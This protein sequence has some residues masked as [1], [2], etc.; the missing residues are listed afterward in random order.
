MDKFTPQQREAITKEGSNLLV[1]ASAGAGKTTVLVNRLIRKIKDGTNVDELLV[2]TFTKA[3]A[4]EMKTRISQEIHA[5]LN[6]TDDQEVKRHLTKQI[7]LI[8][9]ANI[10]T[11]HSFC[12]KVIQRY[13]YMI[14]IDPVFRMLTDDT[15]KLLLKEE[16]L[17]QIFDQRLAGGD[18][19]FIELLN[20][21]SSDRNLDQAKEL[22][23]TVYEFAVSKPDPLNWL[24]NLD[25]LYQN[26]SANNLGETTVYT[27]YLK[28]QFI[29]FFQGIIEEYDYILDRVNDYPLFEKSA[30]LLQKEKD[31]CQALIESIKNGELVQV[32]DCLTSQP[33]GRY[34]T[35]P[36]DANEEEKAFNTANRELRNQLKDQL[37]DF[38]ERYFHTD[39]KRLMEI[40]N[41]SKSIV[42][43][44]ASVVSEFMDRYQQAKAERKVLDFNDLE[45][46]TLKILTKPCVDSAGQSYLAAT[47]ASDYYRAL[48]KEVM[49]D[50]YQDVNELQETIIRFVSQEVSQAKTTGNQFMVGD[51]KQ[52]IYGFRLADPTLFADKYLKFGENQYGERIILA[53][54][55]RSREQVLNFTNFI[56]QQLM[57]R[58]FGDI[59]YDEKAELVNGNKDFPESNDFSPE[60]L[61]YQKDGYDKGNDQVS[62]QDEIEESID[63]EIQ[64]ISQNIMEWMSQPDKNVWDKRLQEWRQP[65]YSDFAILTP[66]KSN[67]LRIQEIFSSFHIPVVMNET[68]NYFR[69]TEISTILSLLKVI[70]NPR[71]DIPLVAVLRSPIVGLDEPELTEIRLANKQGQYYDAIQSYHSKITTTSTYEKLSR[72]LDQLKNWRKRANQAP[73]VDLI[74]DIYFD[75][76]YLDY[77]G[78]L[79]NGQQRQANLHALYERAAQYEENGFKGLFQF[80]RFIEK[81]QKKEKDLTQPKAYTDQDNA[82]NVMTIHASKGLEFPIVYLLNT[83]K[84]F[85]LSDAEGT[86][87]LNEDYGVGMVYRDPEE[88][89]E[90]PTW[91]EAFL[92]QKRK[93][94]LLAEQLR[95]LYVALTRAEQ[96]INIVGSI[97]QGDV[98][99][100]QAVASDKSQIIAKEKRLKANSFLTWILQAL[101]R[102][103]DF[104][105]KGSSLQK[106]LP[107]DDLYNQETSVHFKEKV[108]QPFL[109]YHIQVW[110]EEELL[111]NEQEI[112]KNQ[113]SQTTLKEGQDWLT[114]LENQQSLEVPDEKLAAYLDKA[115]QIMFNPYPHQSATE[116]PSF[117]T[118]SEIK[119]VFEEPDDGKSLR[120]E[121]G[122]HELNKSKHLVVDELEKPKFIE[123]QDPKVSGSDLGNA[124]HLILQEVDLQSEISPPKIEKMLDEMVVNQII[125][126]EAQEKV[127]ISAIIN[128]FDSSLGKKIRQHASQVKREVPFSLMIEAHK[129]FSNIH[130]PKDHILIHGI[131]D[132]YFIDHNNHLILFDYK[133]DYIPPNREVREFLTQRYQSQLTLY[134]YALETILNRPVDQVIMISLYANETIEI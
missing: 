85:N 55:F 58:S 30:S 120:L 75:T 18:T 93:E 63:G 110:N 115:R 25:H 32:Y 10:S 100:W 33:F 27:D 2:V 53:E 122:L 15:E 6:K 89:I 77:T 16:I 118:V 34:P 126:Q 107:M 71:Q 116:A 81:M 9:Q 125:S 35:V 91:P 1:S 12:T 80:I 51:I 57:D 102:R 117:R 60:L 14:D 121:L 21:F 65:K 88:R 104:M 76:G 50:E 72:F 43:T 111:T 3:A 92:K 66:T 128:F 99:Q 70:D 67:N 56:F 97:S 82:V 13:Y 79:V 62:A 42:L 61:L 24:A 40:F 73:L 134:K 52:S 95:V 26:K 7:S 28:S 69:T 68:Q 45:H 8:N 83:N 41:Q 119:R 47:E 84:K 44:I 133:T 49:V 22:I 38:K 4:K 19:D 54:N 132:G 124:T 123:D 48:F 29:D 106:K 17:N 129:L 59:D 96:K 130:S 98:N 23:L 20:Q 90:Y 86:Y 109:D 37:K 131:V 87:A 78:G 64:I 39:P 114:Y 127:D 11:I 74:W 101:I 105:T 94:K 103:K 113:Q 112:L 36:K 5:S 31:I 46:Y 108:S